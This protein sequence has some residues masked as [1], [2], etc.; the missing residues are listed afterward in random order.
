M[1]RWSVRKYFQSIFAKIFLPM[2]TNRHA[3]VQNM[4]KH[5]SKHMAGRKTQKDPLETML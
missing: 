5:A 4:N 1:I 2:N 3:N